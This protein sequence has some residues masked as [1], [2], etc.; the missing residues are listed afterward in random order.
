MQYARTYERLAVHLRNAKLG[1]CHNLTPESLLSS[2][3]IQGAREK[4]LDMESR[5]NKSR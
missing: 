3:G 4:V 1:I 5:K 2:I